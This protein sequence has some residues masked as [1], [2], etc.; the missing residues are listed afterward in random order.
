MKAICIL[1]GNIFWLFCI[2][3]IYFIPI[4]TFL[5]YGFLLFGLVYYINI[6]Y[7]NKSVMYY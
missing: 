2:I 5:K 3:K 6:T 7:I 1:F 4:N